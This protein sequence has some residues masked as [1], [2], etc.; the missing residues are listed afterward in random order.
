[1]SACGVAEVFLRYGGNFCHHFQAVYRKQV[2]LIYEYTFTGIHG[3]IPDKTSI[4]IY[5]RE[6]IKSYK[7]QRVL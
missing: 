3:V 7:N 5:I 6:S 2:A 4:Y 1:M